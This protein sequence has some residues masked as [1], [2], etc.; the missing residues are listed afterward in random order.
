MTLGKHGGPV[1]TS[2][3]KTEYT[4]LKAGREAVPTQRSSGHVIKTWGSGDGSPVRPDGT[5]KLRSGD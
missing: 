4:K 3:Q 1:D 5:P 2:R